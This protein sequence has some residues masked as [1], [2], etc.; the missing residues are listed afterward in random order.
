MQTHLYALKLQPEEWS[1]MAGETSTMAVVV[2]G[3]VELPPPPSKGSNAE[4]TFAALEGPKDDMSSAWKTLREYWTKPL[5]K[6]FIGAQRMLVYLGSSKGGR[7]TEAIER[8]L[9]HRADRMNR[10]NQKHIASF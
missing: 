7:S 10:S 8:R 1:E 2:N 3:P 4:L 9:I 6:R 5:D